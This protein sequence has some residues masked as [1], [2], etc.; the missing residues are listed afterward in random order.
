[1]KNPVIKTG[2]LKQVQINKSDNFNQSSMIKI[3]AVDFVL[4]LYMSA[5][6]ARSFDNANLIKN[7]IYEISIKEVE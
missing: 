3:G 6:E 2:T 4:E 1:M 7:K 5:D